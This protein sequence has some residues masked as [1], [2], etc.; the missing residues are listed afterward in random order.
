MC[1]GVCFTV[2]GCHVQQCGPML[3]RMHQYSVYGFH[4]SGFFSGAGAELAGQTGLPMYLCM[5]EGTP[6]SCFFRSFSAAATT[7]TIAGMY[8]V[9]LSLPLALQARVLA[10]FFTSSVNNF[11]EASNVTHTCHVTEAMAI[12]S[13]YSLFALTSHKVDVAVL[14]SSSVPRYSLAPMVKNLAAGIEAHP[15]LG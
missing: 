3:I 4:W 12:S 5:C 1:V 15:L 10:S 9:G 14:F 8:E 11:C 13:R 6:R 2:L 7:H